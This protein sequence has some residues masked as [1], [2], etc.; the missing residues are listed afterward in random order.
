MKGDMATFANAETEVL[1]AKWAERITSAWRET[2]RG[3]IGVGDLLVEAREDLKPFRGEWSR[4][5]GDNGQQSKLPFGAAS[6]K[7]LIAIAEDPRIRSHVN[8]LR[9][10]G[11][12]LRVN[13]IDRPAI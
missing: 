5:I 1:L 11:H 2:V 10:M 13:H 6:A 8:V 12:P 3:I 9:R 4:L 7:R